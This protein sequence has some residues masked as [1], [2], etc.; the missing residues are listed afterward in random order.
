MSEK[1]DAYVAKMKSKLDKW[2]SEID[3]MDAKGR[4][5]GEET[6]AAFKEQI[7]NLQAK[8]T[9]ANLK[10]EGVRQAGEAAW[11]DMR[12]GVNT[13]WKTL[14]KAVRTAMANF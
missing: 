10:I 11:K 3:K 9:E 1:R 6:K 14:R 2:S 4:E 7:A 12:T 13:S 5:A 8:R